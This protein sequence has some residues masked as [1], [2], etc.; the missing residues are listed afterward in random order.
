MKSIKDS[1]IKDSE[2]VYRRGK[3]YIK[4]NKIYRESDNLNES[5]IVPETDIKDIVDS[6]V[7][8]GEAIRS[9]INYSTTIGQPP[10]TSD[11][12]INR[13]TNG[14]KPTEKYSSKDT[15][16]IVT[17]SNNVLAIRC[18]DVTPQF[19]DSLR[20]TDKEDLPVEPKEEKTFITNANEKDKPTIED[21][22][23]KELKESDYSDIYGEDV[24]YTNVR[25]FI[26]GL[27][28]ICDKSKEDGFNFYDKFEK[29]INSLSNVC[30][31]LEEFYED[32]LDESQKKVKESAED[33]HNFWKKVD[34]GEIKV[35]DIIETSGAGDV[36]IL[37]LNKAADYILVNRPGIEYVA[38]WAPALNDEGKLFWGQGHYFWDEQSAKEYFD[39][40]K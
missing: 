20:L 26:S 36:E 24:D 4:N 30:A 27:R 1:F 23:K 35:G 28:A 17:S 31:D 40:K 6:Y 5:R 14:Y 18:K 19:D 11:I 3:F 22:T 9:V 25:K 38:A 2:G 32:H 33:I 15:V 10:R 39:S 34:D 12:F 13:T 37:A 8:I 21:I 7:T 16:A 29:A